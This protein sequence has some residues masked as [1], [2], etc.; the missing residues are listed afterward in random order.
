M[1]FF[2][3]GYLGEIKKEIKMTINFA[4]SLGLKRAAF[5]NFLPLPGTEAYNNL[6]RSG[7]LKEEKIDWSNIF[8]ADVPYIPPSSL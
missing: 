8:Q 7:E 4:K 2:I 1:V 5:Y 6:I 3:L